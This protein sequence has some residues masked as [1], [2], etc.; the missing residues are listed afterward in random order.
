MKKEDFTYAK[1]KAAVEKAG[2]KFFTGNMNLNQIGVRSKNRKVDGWDDFF[3]ACWQE[4][5]KNMIWVDDQFTTDPG[6]VY[7]QQK[8]LNPNGCGILARGQHRGIWKIDKHQGKYEALC[9]RSGPVMFYRDRNMDN[10]MD[11]DPKTLQSGM[12]GCNHHHGYDSAKVGP[13]S[14]MCQVHRYKKDL[15]YVLSLAKKNTAAGWGD[16]FTYTLL[17]EGIDF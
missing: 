16:T 14:A 2:F 10:I 7:M 4:N 9:Q 3:I 1:V 11:F 5:G 17:E 15:A 6:I 12:V 13:N 8:L